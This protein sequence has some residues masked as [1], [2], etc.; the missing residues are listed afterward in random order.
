MPVA[1]DKRSYALA[2]TDAGREKLKA[3]AAHAAVHDR[4]LDRIAGPKKAELLTLLRR[5]TALLD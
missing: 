4:K 3:L 2:L 1:G 5:I